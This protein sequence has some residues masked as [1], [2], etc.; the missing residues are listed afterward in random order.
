M[1]VSVWALSGWLGLEAGESVEVGGAHFLVRPALAMYFFH[2]S[3]LAATALSYL[4]P[5]S[6]GMSISNTIS[7]APLGSPV[8]STTLTSNKRWRHIYYA[9]KLLPGIGVR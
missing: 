7:P 3:I 6:C 1:L 5:F 2:S 4:S 9:S 8:T